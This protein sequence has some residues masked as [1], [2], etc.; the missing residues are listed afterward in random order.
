VASQTVTRL[1]PLPSLDCALKG[2]YL[3]EALHR[4]GVNDRPLVYTNF[5]S[6]LDGRIAV[7]DPRTGRSKVPDAIA[8]PR[9]WRL[10][11]EL[12]AQADV[13]LVSARYLREL[14]EGTAQD[15]LPVSG[16][17]EFGDLHDWRRAQGLAPQPAVVI[18]SKSL[19]LPLVEL[20]SGMDREV[21]VAAG[22]G[23][24]PEAA[25][26]VERTG[27]RL[28]WVGEGAEVQGK[29]LVD[30]L[31]ARGFRSVYSMAGPGVLQTL[32][33]DRVLDRL[34]LTHVH[35]LLGSTAYNTLLEGDRLSPPVDFRPRAL[36]LDPH[37]GTDFG[38][39][40]GVYEAIRP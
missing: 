36:Y 1:F 23:V 14:A 31:A 33:R 10:F 40:F 21:F 38:Q 39:V 27:A 15:V 9:D 26:S 17:V 2:L 16:D 25:R 32:L 34:Y 24:D 20:C 5:I 19:D 13:L 29:A 35:R 18:L 37:A 6:S 8:N 22:R 28:L 7:E 3:D 12:A 4:R 11:Q 30:T